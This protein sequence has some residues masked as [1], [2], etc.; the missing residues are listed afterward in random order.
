[1]GV[2]DILKIDGQL[3][4]CTMST[5]GIGTWVCCEVYAS[6]NDVEHRIVLEALRKVVNNDKAIFAL[7]ILM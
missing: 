1:M 3:L 6:N 5:L 2:I 7:V 4:V